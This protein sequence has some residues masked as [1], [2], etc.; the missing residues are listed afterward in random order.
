MS[1]ASFSFESENQLQKEINV[2]LRKLRIEH[3]DRSSI[4]DFEMEEE[5]GYEYNFFN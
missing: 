5:S 1:K 2:V 4:N 3:R